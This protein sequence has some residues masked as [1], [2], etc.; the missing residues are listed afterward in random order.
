MPAVGRYRLR[1]EVETL[2]ARTLLTASSLAD[3]IILAP[4]Q[5]LDDVAGQAGQVDFYAVTVPENGRLTVR[6]AST[7]LTPTLSL[8][9]TTGEL[10]IQGAV[11]V[12]AEQS[13]VLEQHLLPGTYVFRVELTAAGDDPGD[14][15][16]ET[17]FVAAS[18]PF[19]PVPTG[20]GPTNVKG[21]TADFNG[22]GHLDLAV[23]RQST[24]QAG[25]LGLYFG[26]GDGTFRPETRIPLEAVV[27][28]TLRTFLGGTL[29]AGYF[30]NDDHLDIALTV[31]LP[32]SSSADLWV[33]LGDG[34]GNFEP[35]VTTPAL[36]LGR[37]T[38]L[39]T[40]D[41]NDDG[42]LDVAVSS[43]DRTQIQVLLG[44]GD[45]RFAEPQ[46]FLV[47]G[48][49]QTLY[50][51]DWNN[52]D[53][54][55]LAVANSNGHVAVL[56]GNGDGSFLPEVRYTVG[57]SPVS[58]LAF[59]G[60]HDGFLELVVGDNADFTVSL[61]RNQG[62]GTFAPGVAFALAGDMADWVRLAVADFDQ[63]GW[64][65]L[66]AGTTFHTSIFL[67]T[68]EGIFA[69][70]RALVLDRG[71]ATLLAGDFNG[72]G[73]AD[74]ASLN[75]VGNSQSTAFATLAFGLGNGWFRAADDRLG[76]ASPD[77]V[78]G[79]LN[80]DGFLDLV[81]LF[82]E[83][84]R[85]AV[86]L[87]QG[88]GTF[89]APQ[90]FEIGE[91]GALLLGDANGDGRLDLR[92]ADGALV[93][94]GRGDG[95]FQGVP[96]NGSLTLAALRPQGGNQAVG[97]LNDD[98]FL[99][100][101]FV[102]STAGNQ[103]AVQLGAAG[104]LLPP[105]LF[106]VGAGPTSLALGDYDGD[107][108][109]DLAVTNIGN[110]TTDPGRNTVSILLGQGD[111]T[112]AAE[113]RVPVGLAPQRVLAGDFT[114]DGRL[115]LVV[116]LSGQAA[117]ILLV[118]DGQGQFTAAPQAPPVTPHAAPLLVDANGD[119][120]PDLLVVNQAGQ[121]LF[122]AGR[123][124]AA[125]EFAP[126]VVVNPGRPARDVTWVAGTEDTAGFLAA[127]DNQGNSISL[128]TLNA[129]GAFA[130]ERAI[131]TD[132]YVTRVASADLDGDL[133]PD[134][135]AL[136]PGAQVLSVFLSDGA[137]GFGAPIHLSVGSG[138]SAVLFAD[139]DDSGTLDILV[140]GAQS[141]DFTALLNEGGGDWAEPLRFRAGA[142]PYGLVAADGMPRIISQ[143]GTTGLALGALLGD[144]LADLFAVNPG[145]NTVTRMAGQQTGWSAP[146]VILPG[147][148]QAFAIASADLNAD[149]RTD[150]LVLDRTGVSVFL[151]DVNGAFTLAFRADVGS[152]PRG[153]SL[154]HVDDDDHLDLLIG[155]DLGD[156][157]VLKGQGDGTFLPYKRPGS[158][159]MLAV[160]DVDGDRR[161]DF[162]FADGTLDR[163]S[164][165]YARSGTTLER[166]RDDGLLA[167]GAVR[168]AD[169][170][171]DGLPDL[172]IANRNTNQVLVYLGTG[173]GQFGAAH[174]FTVGTSPVGLT[175][176]DLNGDRVLDL[177]VANEGSNDVSVLL[178]Q[179]RG[180]AWTFVP[181]P[182][183][184]AGGGP[185]ATIVRD[186][187][188]DGRPDLLVSN[189][190]T[191]D[192]YLLPGVGQ[193]FFNDTAPTRFVT[194]NNPGSIFV[195]NFDN[196]PGLDLISVNRL[197]NDLTI[198]SGFGAGRS[199]G[200]GGTAPLDA[201]SGD[202]N[203]DGLTDLL[204]AHGDG[205]LAL[206]LGG[207]DGL[208]LSRSL[209]LAFLPA[210]LALS[211]LDRDGVYVQ[212]AIQDT[213]V[214]L[215]LSFDFGLPVL[216]PSGDAVPGRADSELGPLADAALS[217]IATLTGRSRT[218]AAQDSPATD[219]DGAR[220]A[221]IIGI[222]DLPAP[223][224]GGAGGVLDSYLSAAVTAWASRIVSWLSVDWPTVESAFC[225]WGAG[226]ADSVL[227][228]G[229]G[230]DPNFLPWVEAA[231]GLGSLP[232]GVAALWQT[233]AD[234]ASAVRQVLAAPL[235]PI[236]IT[237]M[238]APLAERTDLPAP[239]C[240]FPGFG[241]E[242][243]ALDAEATDI[244]LASQQHSTEPARSAAALGTLLLWLV[245]WTSTF[246]DPPEAA[247]PGLG[248]AR[249]RPARIDY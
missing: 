225:T 182:R 17:Q 155:N 230:E 152:A 212:D 99:D 104:G 21:I 86:F 248:A 115:D 91:G 179:G 198:F 140:A 209:Q 88:D 67:G 231:E 196:L 202:W 191:D 42:E 199:L 149:G 120:T 163:V 82:G 160:A 223:K 207:P 14:Y 129:Q 173:G 227:N 187:T 61:L 54:L 184:A 65:D 244:P 139:V 180:S 59:D 106:N 37:V 15:D 32:N 131:A 240:G 170:N 201:V 233:V 168:V 63:D 85:A 228:G 5:L 64:L 135:V 3:P 237:P 39:V 183:L 28:G 75:S 247:R 62:D 13:A 22:D 92:R 31:T 221:F 204:V 239:P 112:F 12:G 84:G 69:A 208:A 50:A 26:L 137:G 159:Q 97:D 211:A 192:I 18:V 56:L 44:T 93:L 25:Y 243:G 236:F 100:V 124:E 167:P 181:G 87:G 27:S 246:A 102:H 70:P 74:L 235:T 123:A 217:V 226:L 101:V 58:I 47:A 166:T 127:A 19:E 151:T 238:S 147:L 105:L 20:I 136:Q 52:D 107:G 111:G 144:G 76:P 194:G 109:L 156:V 2:E 146:E 78:V 245:P 83:A 175:L 222:A 1:L 51:A 71:T 98:G 36:N 30:N 130:F 55:D 143:E 232:P 145:A 219:A 49:S 113:V 150:L 43:S 142:G 114:G 45:G 161:A 162:I 11:E 249:R 177:V 96:A 53:V 110:N 216:A 174:S 172:V 186:V 224:A 133:Q 138:A 29:V 68:E 205:G 95:T 72:D 81:S 215:S 7:A 4:T 195:G 200:S 178:G 103:L 210:G 77:T 132:S 116:A 66:A 73:R 10:L 188:G 185:V 33:M 141:G 40:G 125:G 57:P 6:T 34:H 41:F 193:G 189:S 35:I 118:G 23:L 117:M 165:T 148:N 128:Y 90:E 190:T 220:L 38:G 206:L 16:L 46:G 134:L 176:A 8:L 234:T 89:R 169:L 9:T 164:V 119:G 48:G 79:D 126:P 60:D 108:R 154:A 153:L 214:R 171:Q 94:L 197:S 158:R 229:A 218:D 80:H 242:P 122:R 24:A 157:L 203:G 121:I 213:V 241:E